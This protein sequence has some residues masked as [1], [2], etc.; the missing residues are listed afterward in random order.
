MY[1]TMPPKH[2]FKRSPHLL[3]SWQVTQPLCFVTARSVIQKILATNLQLAHITPSCIKVN[4]RKDR[5][6]WERKRSMIRFHGNRMP[7][8]KISQMGPQIKSQNPCLSLF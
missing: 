4:H 8:V 5:L 1:V 3:T 7:S 6:K 2:S